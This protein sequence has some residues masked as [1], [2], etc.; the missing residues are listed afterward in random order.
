MR[1]T[2]I[3]F[4]VSSLI[5]TLFCG[6][7]QKKDNPA[8]VIL[9]S[10]YQDNKMDIDVLVDTVEYLPLISDAPVGQILDFCMMDSLVFILDDMQRIHVCSLRTGQVFRSMNYRGHGNAEYI[11]ARAVCAHDGKLFVL[12]FQGMSVL[13]YDHHLDFIDRFK[14]GFP[15][16][17][18]AV[19]DRGLLFF[20]MNATASL[21]RIVCTDFSGQ[22][23]DSWT[24]SDTE[25]NMM[26]SNRIF[27]END[28]G[29]VYY[30]EP[31]SER[32]Y[33]W[34][35]GESSLF[36]T[37]DLGRN[38]IKSADTEMKYERQQVSHVRSLI[39]Q[40]HVLTS[41]IENGFVYYNVYNRATFSSQAGLVST[42][43]ALPFFPSECWNGDLYGIYD[44]PWGSEMKLD[45]DGQ[46]GEGRAEKMMVRYVMSR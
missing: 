37:V 39:S 19:T 11:D 33:C 2:A 7:H 17:D 31:L 40:Y 30:M 1:N 46:F 32:I 3:L 6:C 21:G 18:F 35:D 10:D 16:W 36:C 13:I 28:S 5:C 41:F 26:L 43:A 15:A 22:V 25:M 20:N 12:D 45:M 44:I 27:Q 29:G 34:K 24:D 42:H 4:T 38:S 9:V 23:L 14:T 8:P